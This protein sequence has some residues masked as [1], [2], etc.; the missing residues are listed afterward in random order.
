MT[1]TTD[2]PSPLASLFP[3]YFALVMATGIVS[4][5][6]H[7]LGMEP[8][9]QVLLWINS[10]AYI[11]LWILTLARLV[12]YPSNVMGDLT[13]HARSVLFL[14]MVAGTCV[15]GNQFAVMTTWLPL[16]AWLWVLGM[17]LWL[18]LIYTFFTV[19]TVRQPKP[20]FENVINGA[21]LLVVVA[22][23]SLCVLGALVD[24]A[25][26]DPK[27]VL[28]VSLALYLV[29]LLLYIPLITLILYRW[30]F[31]SMKADNLTPPY[32]INM[33]ALAISTLA[34]SRLLLAAKDWDWMQGMTP[35]LLGLTFLAWAM[36]TW[37]IPLL[38]VVGIWRHVVER[39][40]LRYDP[41]YWSMVFPLGMYT[42]ATYIMIRAT[43]LTMLSAIPAVFVFVALAAWLITFAG[44]L[45][46]VG[47]SFASQLEKAPRALPRA[48]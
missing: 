34:G 48:P 27:I 33:G 16:A 26:G 39:V 44:M 13:H 35:V 46:H 23:E 17:V 30:M 22:T 36:A 18:A 41:Q 47:R 19:V 14:T 3:G 20:S 11:V 24:G 25:F 32:W 6:A 37:W 9:A 10:A 31:F 21:W 38:V 42:V 7:F 40:L 2:M 28:L 12:R 45:L 1:Q 8:I 4:I 15:L 5:G 29:G 43:G